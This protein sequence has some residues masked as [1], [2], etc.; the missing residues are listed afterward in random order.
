M[1]DPS[2]N[3]IRGNILKQDNSIFSFENTFLD[4]KYKEL[5]QLDPKKSFPVNNITVK[6]INWIKEIIIFFTHH[7]LN[8]SLSSSTFSMA[9]K[10]ANVKPVFKKDDKAQ[11]ENYRPISIL[12]IFSMVYERYI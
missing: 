9:L 12:T 6:I 7:K 2:L 3:V 8:K 11:K 1:N 5:K 4:R 10:Y